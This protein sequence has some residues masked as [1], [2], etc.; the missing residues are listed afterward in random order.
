[1]Y[2]SRDPISSLSAHSGK[3][4]AV[5][6]QREGGVSMAEPLADHTDRN[7]S[8]HGNRCMR[9]AEVVESEYGKAGVV[10][11]PSEGRRQLTRVDSGS[12]TPAKDI[13]FTSIPIQVD[14]TTLLL[15]LVVTM[16][17]IDR[18]PIEINRSPTSDSSVDDT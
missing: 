16:Q 5:A 18:V 11:D 17:H 6:G 4:V 14:L 13:A 12:V 3:D 10:G 2:R 15:A 1:M 8:F 9:M 7:T